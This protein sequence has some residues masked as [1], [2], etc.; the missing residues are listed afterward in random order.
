REAARA[1]AGWVR[2]GG[3]ARGGGDF[4]LDP[5][6]VDAGPKTFLKQSGP[7]KP[8]DIVRI[9]LEQPAAAEFLCRKLY[10]FLVSEAKEPAPELIRPLAQELRSHRYSVRHVAEIILRSRHFY[11]RENSRQ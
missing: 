7:W 8:A 3:D 10:R 1:F 11:A 9:T 5:R 4:V 2:R 6:E